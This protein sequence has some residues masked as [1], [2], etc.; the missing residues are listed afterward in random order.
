MRFGY[1]AKF[2]HSSVNLEKGILFYVSTLKV[3]QASNIDG[4]VV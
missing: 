2:Q 4:L 1:A 3:N